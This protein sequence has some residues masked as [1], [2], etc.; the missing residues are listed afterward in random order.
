MYGLIG[1]IQV[2]PGQR[3][4]VVQALLE[5]PGAMSM[6]GAELILLCRLPRA[7]QIAQRSMRGHAGGAPSMLRRWGIGTRAR[8]SG[9]CA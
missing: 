4:V 8:F 6:A 3:A 9:R 2:T 5:G 1:K 7:H